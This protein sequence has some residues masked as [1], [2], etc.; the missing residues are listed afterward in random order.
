VN[1]ALLELVFFCL[2]IIQEAILNSANVFVTYKYSENTWTKLFWPRKTLVHKSV[3][4]DN[5][6]VWLAIKSRCR[7]F[8]VL[9]GRLQI[10]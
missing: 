7:G 5:F 2:Q 6:N 8:S 3:S 1:L 4:S 9:V 10:L